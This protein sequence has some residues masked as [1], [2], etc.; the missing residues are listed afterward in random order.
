MTDQFIHDEAAVT[1]LQ[2]VYAPVRSCRGPYPLL[3]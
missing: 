1:R 3:E 2:R